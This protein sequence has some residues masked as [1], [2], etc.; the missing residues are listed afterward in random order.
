MSWP[1]LREA[2]RA[3]A[4]LGYDETVTVEVSGGSA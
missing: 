3:R 4:F 2:I 1:D